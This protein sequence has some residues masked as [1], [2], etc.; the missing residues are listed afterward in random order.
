MAKPAEQAGRDQN[1]RREGTLVI[2]PR[3]DFKARPPNVE[4]VRVEIVSRNSGNFSE[5]V[6][7]SEVVDE[8]PRYQAWLIREYA[9]AMD[10]PKAA[11]PCLET[12]QTSVAWRLRTL[13]RRRL[14]FDP[15]LQP[16][17]N[18]Y[19]GPTTTAGQ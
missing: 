1:R 6:E 2:K 7:A 17:L 14:G 4:H 16:L 19:N 3:Q 11:G 9:F 15:E 13:M 10:L 18:V 8:S 12:D 5:T